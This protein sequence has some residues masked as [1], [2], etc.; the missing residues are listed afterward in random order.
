M[1]QKIG[2]MKSPEEPI[3][4]IDV[5]FV[6]LYNLLY[7]K[8]EQEPDKGIVVSKGNPNQRKVTWSKVMSMAHMMED[9][10]ILRSEKNGEHY[11]GEC[12]HWKSCS[13]ASPHMGKCDLKGERYVHRL[14]LCKKFEGGNK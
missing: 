11:C 3:N 8:I 6:A 14:A 4:D 5:V 13:K 7:E 9:Y 12:S 2:T 10:F 1:K